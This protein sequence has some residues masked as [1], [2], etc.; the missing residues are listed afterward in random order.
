MNYVL[1]QGKVRDV[2]DF[3]DGNLSMFYSNRL[4]SYDRI[5]CE[6]PNKGLYLNQQTAW[7]FKNTSGIIPNHMISYDGNMMFV[8]KCDRIEL[9]VV[10]RAYITG[11]TKTSLW[12]M[13]NS[14]KRR[15][16]GHNFSDNMRKNQKLKEIVVTPT[17]KGEK[18]D[19]P[20]SELEIVERGILSEDDWLYVRN[21]ALELFKYGQKEA[22]KRGLI[23]VDTKYEFGRDKGGSIILIDEMHTCD[24]SRYWLKETYESRFQNGEEP[25]SIDKDI[26]RRWIK[27]RCDPYKTE[28]L[29]KIPEELI[30][31]V[32]EVYKDFTEKLVLESMEGKE[33]YDSEESR[34]NLFKGD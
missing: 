9:E 22:D 27:D 7:W 28:N 18:S 1:Y 20:L 33:S 13:Y 32:S 8:K 15:M 11:S 4:S 19:D 26:I 3:N 6:V 16:Y 31:K 23:L 17:T 34:M 29:P 14:G 10:V 5:I 21:H 24:S 2:Y 25:D 12:T 30:Q